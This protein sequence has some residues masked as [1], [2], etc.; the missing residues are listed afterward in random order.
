VEPFRGRT[1][2]EV[3][4]SLEACPWRGSR[5]LSLPHSL[6][7]SSCEVSRIALQHAF[8]M[9]CIS[10][11]AQS[12]LGQSAWTASSKTGSQNEHFL[13]VNWLSQA[14]CYSNRK[15]TKTA[16][17]KMCLK[18]WSLHIV[19]KFLIVDFRTIIQCQ[20]KMI[21]CVRANMK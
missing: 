21:T 5:P 8:V 6:F 11:Q 7:A 20:E 12:K 18:I 14:F 3:F 2:W 4:R 17:N 19:L 1:K 13:S 15:L 9:M 16:S 10:P